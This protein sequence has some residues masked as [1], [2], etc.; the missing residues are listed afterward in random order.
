MDEKSTQ[1]ISSNLDLITN[2]I[3]SLDNGIIIRNNN[4]IIYHFNNWLELH[5]SRK[6]EDLLNKNITDI[7]TNVNEITLKRKI[8]TTLNMGTTTFYTANTSKDLIPIKINQITVSSFNHMRQDVSVIPLDTE[9][10][11]VAL[12]ITD[13]TNITN[14]HHLL[15]ISMQKIRELNNEL[16]KERETIDERIILIKIN[17]KHILTE[18]SMAYIKLFEYEKEDIL[19]KNIF[20]IKKIIMPKELKKSIVFNINNKQVFK[21]E[22]MCLTASREEI[23]LANT[24]VP[25]YS[26]NGEHI[27]FI[28]F[29]EDITDAIIIQKN[30]EKLLQ[31]SRA[32]VMGE[33][34]SM[35]AHQWRQPLSIIN[36][37]IA[38]LKIKKQ[39]NMIDDKT[40]DTS[41]DKI[42]NTVNY[43]SETIDDFRNFFK[44]N[45]QIQTLTVNNIIDKSEDLLLG[46]IGINNIKYLKEVN[47][48]LEISTYTNEL[49]QTIINI[50]KNSIDAFVEDPKEI[51]K[52]S[53]KAYEKDEYIIIEIEDNAGGI[54]EDVMVK[55][56]EPYFSTKSKNGTGLGLYICKTIIEDHLKGTITMQSNNNKTKTIIELQ[57]NIRVQGET[58]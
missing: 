36:T 1:H 56:Y 30:Q 12:I 37:L 45:K 58:I 54:T 24:L 23:H 29:S 5:T 51:Q 49:I 41:Y 3:S 33:M 26:K 14:M 40:I 31:N 46:D 57:K 22:N 52:I 34:I 28:I 11:L 10:N 55:V 42:E 38:T 15:E 47:P 18:A 7:F 43:L 35:I 25:E 2:L 48:D 21:Y 17:N 27:G 50:L 39:L 9:K 44:Q 6:E 32:S 8:R 20:E 4:L 16:I 53:V 19:N 13:Q